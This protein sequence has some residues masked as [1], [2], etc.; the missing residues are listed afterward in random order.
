MQRICAK[1][2]Y[3]RIPYSIVVVPEDD[4]AF[5]AMTLKRWK[6]GSKVV[7]DDYYGSVSLFALFIRGPGN[8]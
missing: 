2:C 7:M 1:T 3:D 8:I 4:D 6:D 5:F